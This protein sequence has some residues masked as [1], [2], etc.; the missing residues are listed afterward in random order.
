MIINRQ[1]ALVFNPDRSVNK[2]TFG[3]RKFFYCSVQ[4]E[5]DIVIK[6]QTAVS[7]K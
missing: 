3:V 5:F 7:K 4:R 1:H 2:K 6:T